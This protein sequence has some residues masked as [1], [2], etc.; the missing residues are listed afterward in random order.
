LL[1]LIVFVIRFI[2]H[3]MNTVKLPLRLDKYC[4]L[5]DRACCRRS[6]SVAYCT[7]LCALV[8]NLRVLPYSLEIWL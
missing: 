8:E 6:Y 7:A 3:G 1:L 2:V 5:G 4:E